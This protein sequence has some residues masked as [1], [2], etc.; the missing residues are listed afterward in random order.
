MRGLPFPDGGR[1]MNVGRSN[2]EN[3][4]T[5]TGYSPIID[6]DAVRARQSSFEDLAGWTTGTMNVSGAEG[7]PERFRGGFIP[8][9]AFG[10][11]GV[12]PLLGRFFT[13]EEGRHGGPP[14]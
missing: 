12:R 14:A 6:F 5:R 11:L 4:V 7:R 3:G 8:A 1:I 13:E 9:N 2:P 10:M